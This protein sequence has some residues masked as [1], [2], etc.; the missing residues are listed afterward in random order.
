MAVL[1]GG[2]RFVTAAADRTAKLVDARGEPSAPSSLAAA[3]S[4][5]HCVPDG[6]HFVVVI[7]DYIDSSSADQAVPRRRHARPHLQGTP[8]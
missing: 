8:R 3:T 6:M 4:I 7:S 1:P 5:A 2:L